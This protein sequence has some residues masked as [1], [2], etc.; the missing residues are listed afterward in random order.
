MEIQYYGANSVRV[1]TKKSVIAID[2]LSDIVALKPDFKK[3]TSVVLTNELLGGGVPSDNFVISYPGEYEFEDF[4]VKGIASQLHTASTGDKSST[5]YK[6]I[7]NDVRLLIVGHIV[8]KLTEEQL[9]EIGVVDVVII[10]VGGSGYTLDAVDA[11]A[12]VR[13]LGPKLVVP[14]HCNEDAVN[15]SIA[16]DSRE[17]FIKELSAPVLD[18]PIEKLKIKALP[19]QMSIQVL[20]RS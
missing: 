13:S 4:S 19:E 9:E 8:G 20:N 2:P 15:Y 16:Q 17:L 6:I 14:V 5:V 12:V 18:G 10:P 3:V 7:S 11:A 1:N